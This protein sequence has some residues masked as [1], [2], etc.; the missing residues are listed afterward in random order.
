MYDFQLDRNTESAVGWEISTS[1]R[2]S[3]RVAYYDGGAEVI[4]SAGLPAYA[5][6]PY[7]QLQRQHLYIKK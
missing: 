4:N 7:S 6:F 5:S 1:R 2:S 3:G